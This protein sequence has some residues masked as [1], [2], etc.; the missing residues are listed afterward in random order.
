M[1]PQYI[2]WCLLSWCASL[3]FA[4]RFVSTGLT[5][6]IA[7]L[8][9]FGLLLVLSYEPP[10]VG[11]HLRCYSRIPH[12]FCQWRLVPR[13]CLQVVSVV[14]TSAVSPKRCSVGTTLCMVLQVCTYGFALLHVLLCSGFVVHL[15]ILSPAGSCTR[16]SL[17]SLVDKSCA[18]FLNLKRSL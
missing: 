3:D 14:C 17:Y 11:R 5:P 2:L 15:V 8:C 6:L 16:R 9:H 12:T 18:G 7:P 4:L 13:T 1:C 10:D